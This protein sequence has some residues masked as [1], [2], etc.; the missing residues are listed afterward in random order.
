MWGYHDSTKEAWMKEGVKED[1]ML[2]IRTRWVCLLKINNS[3][4]QVQ[5]GIYEENIEDD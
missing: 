2:N 4:K 1:D 3:E 5:F